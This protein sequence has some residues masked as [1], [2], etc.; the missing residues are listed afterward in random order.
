MDLLLADSTNWIAPLTEVGSTVALTLFFGWLIVKH[1]PAQ[2]ERHRAE[3]SEW[4]QFLEERDIKWQAFINSR[5]GRVSE[6]VARLED[7]IRELDKHI[8][9]E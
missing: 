8:T 9:K 5:D 6:A 2:E 4:L 3:R 1:L 7:A